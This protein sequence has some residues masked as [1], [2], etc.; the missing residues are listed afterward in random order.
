M[1]KENTA[2]KE[3][4]NKFASLIVSGVMLLFVAGCQVHTPTPDPLAGWHF[5][6]RTKVSQAITADYKS[7]IDQLP[8]KERKYV[9]DVSFFE[10]DY[11]QHA[12]AIEVALSGVWVE[13][14]LIYD[15][16]DKR[17]KTIKYGNGRYSS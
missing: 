8:N 3:S 14:V 15:K 11:G 4:I 10:N 17:V 16:D 6:S 1:N 5:Y 12:V 7:Y 13:H 9:C 2:V